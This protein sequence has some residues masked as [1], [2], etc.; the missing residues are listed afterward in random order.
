MRLRPRTTSGTRHHPATEASREAN[1]LLEKA[2]TGG[3]ENLRDQA[4]PGTVPPQEVLA[5]LLAESATRHR[6]LCPRQVL[7]VRLGLGGLRALGL[8]DDNWQPRFDNRRK[9]LLA[10]V[11]LAGCGAD[12]IAVATDCSLGARTLWLQDYGKMAATFVDV[13][14][15]VAIRVAPRAEVR[16]LAQRYAPEARSR[17]HAYLE[18]YHYMPD[19]V[20]LQLQPVR[21][22]RAVAAILSRPGVRVDCHRCGEEIINEREV[23]RDGE[24]LCRA[25]AGDAYYHLI[26]GAV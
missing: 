11:E 12:G 1:M 6:H 3:G 14:R 25:C 16:E 19:E 10:L 18:A 24:I 2:R 21:L 20:L 9:K 4:I 26:D 17:W 13:G 5:P 15:E 22:H 8:M 7:G 23:V